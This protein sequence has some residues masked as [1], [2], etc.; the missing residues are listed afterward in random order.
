MST[1]SWSV[2]SSDAKLLIE[3]DLPHLAAVARGKRGRRSKAETAAISAAAL[4]AK[5]AV[6]VN[7]ENLELA[8]LIGDALEPVNQA[9]FTRKTGLAVGAVQS[10]VL[11]RSYPL[12]ATLDGVVELDGA[13]L[14]W[15]GKTT[16]QY[17]KL[18]DLIERNAPQ[19]QAQMMCLGA[20][21][22]V[23]SVLWRTPKWEAV[24][25][26]A[27]DVLQAEILDRLD[28]LALHIEQGT[29]PPTLPPADIPTPKWRPLAVASASVTET[30]DHA[31]T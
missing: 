18:P 31:L 22:A 24:V 14:P 29:E 17:T 15:E 26:E 6:R 13:W 16:S 9:W 4:R 2:G 10:R 7:E 21:A 27:D 11:H 1:W 8:M 28:L 5:G 12:H 25:V 30:A 3:G 23:V 19:L 20:Q